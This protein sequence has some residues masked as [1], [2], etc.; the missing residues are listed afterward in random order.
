ALLEA[1]LPIRHVDSLQQELSML[2]LDDRELIRWCGEAG[3]GGGTY[4][5][6]GVGFLTGRYTRAEADRIDD[7][8]SRNGWTDPQTL[9]DVF[10]VVD[11]LRP[12]GEGLGVTNGEVSLAVE[13]G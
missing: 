2:V 6:R 11:G 8:R 12:I 7:W 4:S 10:R 3:I 1:C 9:D 5:P 13:R